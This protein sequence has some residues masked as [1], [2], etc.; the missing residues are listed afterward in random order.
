M[1]AFVEDARKSGMD[2][3]RIADAVK[4]H[5]DQRIKNYYKK[6]DFARASDLFDIEKLKEEAR[7]DSKIEGIFYNELTDS[8]IQFEFQVSIGRYRADYLIKKF[9]I[10]EIDGPQHLADPAAYRRDRRKDALLQEHGCHVLRFLAEDLA[11][12]LD[13]TLDAI[14]RAVTHQRQLGVGQGP[15][16]RLPW[17]L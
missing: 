8:G 13:A 17:P 5:V 1:V 14:A 16:E 10:V 9:L 6:P 12:H 15:P 11:E 4:S 3:G 2:E 7:A